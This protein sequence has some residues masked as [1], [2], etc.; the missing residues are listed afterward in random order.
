MEPDKG[1]SPTKLSDVPQHF[2]AEF[3]ENKEP[4]IFF[5]SRFD[6]GNMKKVVR[7][8]YD[9]YS[10]WTASDAEGSPNE[11]YPKSWFY[12]QV[13]GFRNRKVTFSIHRVHFLWAMVLP[14][15]YLGTPQS[16][17]SARVPD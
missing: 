14:I 11:G 4:R 12:F 5:N 8:S 6:S 16:S 9:H 10:I 1:A 2:L 15:L 13:G 17:I 7:N 3:S